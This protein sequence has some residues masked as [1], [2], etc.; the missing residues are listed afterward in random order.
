MVVDAVVR[1]VD[2]NVSVV[3]TWSKLFSEP[4]QRH[5]RMAY[6]SFEAR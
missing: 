4:T 2:V 5:Q 1:I 3:D 6:Q